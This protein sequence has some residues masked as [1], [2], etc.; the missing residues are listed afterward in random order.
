[1]WGFLRNE[2]AP[3]PFFPARGEPATGC[4]SQRVSVSVQKENIT[5][6]AFN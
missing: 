4:G 6:K 3:S 2:S 5:V 1:M